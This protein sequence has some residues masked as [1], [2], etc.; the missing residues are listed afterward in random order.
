MKDIL[1][2]NDDLQLINGDFFAGESQNQSV[3]MLLKSMQ[4]EWK[5]HPEAGCGLEKAQNGVIDRFF[6]RN[7][8]V[9]LEADGFDIEKLT[10]N[11]KGIELKG[12]YE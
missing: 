6:A 2:E 5:E 1:L 10:I 9:Q 4:G 11:E 7:I 8:R 12:N 3:E